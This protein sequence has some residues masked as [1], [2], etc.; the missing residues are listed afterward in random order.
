VRDLFEGTIIWNTT[1]PDCEE[2]TSTVYE[3]SAQA[4][5]RIREPT[6]TPATTDQS[7]TSAHRRPI[8]WEDAVFI[9]NNQGKEQ[10]AGVVIREP[11]RVCDMLCHSTHIKGIVICI[12]G[13]QPH[14]QKMTFKPSFEQFE[15][16]IE[17]QLAFLHLRMNL[18]DLQRFS[19]LR[20][21]GYRDTR[22][23]TIRGRRSRVYYQV[24]SDRSNTNIIPELHKGDPCH[25]GQ[26][27][28]RRA[29]LC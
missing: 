8:N 3:G 16:N 7:Q 2:R 1:I 25:H 23:P 29:P 15:K 5:R 26:R 4:H 27:Q 6:Q 22:P 19:P 14:V 21:D 10:F 17:T 24:Q 28:R 13:E 12:S 11:T 20:A 9:I 18:D